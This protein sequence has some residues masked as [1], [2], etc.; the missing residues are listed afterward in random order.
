MNE[1]LLGPPSICDGKSFKNHFGL[2][3]EETT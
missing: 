2:V 3:K 1:F